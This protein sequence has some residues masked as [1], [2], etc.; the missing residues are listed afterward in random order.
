MGNKRRHIGGFTNTPLELV[1]FCFVKDPE[2]S[3]RD[4][5]ES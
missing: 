5:Y 1:R 2:G 3:L 4:I